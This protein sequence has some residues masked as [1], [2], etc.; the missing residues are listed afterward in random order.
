MISLKLLAN[1]LT[2]RQ[3]RVVSNNQTSLCQNILAGVPQG[4]VLEPFSFLIYSNDLSHGIAS[5][6]KIFLDNIANFSKIDDKNNYN[7]QPKFDL[8]IIST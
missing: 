3:Q 8:K 6:C 5:V 1:Y 4:S 2:G 7:I